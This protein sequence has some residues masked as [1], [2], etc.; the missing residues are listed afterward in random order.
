M[1]GLKEL[2]T[3]NIL[4]KQCKGEGYNVN[5][6][7]WPKQFKAADPECITQCDKTYPLGVA[8]SPALHSRPFSWICRLVEECLGHSI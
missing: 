7:W 5:G 1:S 8:G 6:F 3:S 2:I 4:N